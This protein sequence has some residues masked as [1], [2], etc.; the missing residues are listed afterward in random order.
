MQDDFN[1][2]EAF[3]VLFDLA[4]QS[5]AAADPVVKTERAGVLK[6]LG[7]ILGL[8]QQDPAAYLKSGGSEGGGDDAEIDAL[9]AARIAAAQGQG[10]Q[11]IRPPPRR[12]E[13]ARHPARGLADRHHL[14][15]RL[16][17]KM[18]GRARFVVLGAVLAVGVMAST[19]GP[20]SAQPYKWTDKDS[21]VHYGDRPP[22]DAKLEEI[23]GNVQVQSFSGAPVVDAVAPG[24]EPARS[25]LLPSTITLYGT[26]WCGFCKK[27]RTWLAA[28][29]VAFRDLDVEQDEAAAAAYR[30]LG[31][32]GV[33]VIVVGNRKMQGWSA[34][35]MEALLKQAG[36]TKS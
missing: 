15:A 27:A 1:T 33:P 18:R 12:A 5:N 19:A 11:G 2:P 20:A 7:A 9:V 26:A 14:A 16:T 34:P 10:F 25:A 24:T 21:I 3:A 23:K 13:G 6:G 31:G 32:S 30:A 4:N 17:Q 36:F 29:G 28:R 8:L 35:Q 22:K